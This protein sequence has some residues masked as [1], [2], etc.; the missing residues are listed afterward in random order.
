[1]LVPTEFSTL[2]RGKN[3][4]TLFSE[5]LT[6]QF[7]PLPQKRKKTKYAISRIST[8]IEGDRGHNFRGDTDRWTVTLILF[9]AIGWLKIFF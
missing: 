7:S 2:R 6:S 1:M 3:F 8:G 9:K 4:D 5:N